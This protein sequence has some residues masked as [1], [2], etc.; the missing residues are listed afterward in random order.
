MQVARESYEFD[1]VER[2]KWWTPNKWILLPTG[3]MPLFLDGIGGVSIFW[4]VILEHGRTYIR[5]IQKFPGDEADQ[6]R[7]RKAALSCVG[8]GYP[9]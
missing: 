4:H 7:M 6:E 5:E 9:W 2:G 1:E 3:W 8:G